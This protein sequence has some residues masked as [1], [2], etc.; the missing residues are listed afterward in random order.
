MKSLPENTTAHLLH[1]FQVT[2]V[3]H[4]PHSSL[5]MM[6]G[7]LMPAP[8]F[9][10]DSYV[11]QAARWYGA[12]S[13]W[14]K[15]LIGL[16]FVGVFAGLGAIG[17]MVVA[18]V[19]AASFVYAVTAMLL[20]DHYS[21]ST[22][23]ELSVQRHLDEWQEMMQ[24]SL[25]HIK[26][27]EVKLDQT[28]SALESLDHIKEQQVD[29]L[30]LKTQQLA[31][32]CDILR[33][34]E[35]LLAGQLDGISAMLNGIVVEETNPAVAA[36]DPQLDQRKTQQSIPELMAERAENLPAVTAASDLLESRLKK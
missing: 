28:F 33:L 30:D 5:S 10:L 25:Q 7:S 29:V 16:V 35:D 23:K 26:E 8:V 17:N 27:Q 32:Q 22:E 13:W 20:Y 6:S 15:I 12:R 36:N 34:A 21:R 3:S 18:L 31:N 11:N 24:D 2:S 1:E 9:K 14:M 4:K 19:I